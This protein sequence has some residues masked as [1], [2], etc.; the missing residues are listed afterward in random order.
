[1]LATP[2]P[3]HRGPPSPTLQPWKGGFPGHESILV[4]YGWVFGPAGSVM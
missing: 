4:D 3:S 1:M 2:W